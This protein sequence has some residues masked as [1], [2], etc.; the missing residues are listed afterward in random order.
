MTQ[1]YSVGRDWAECQRTGSCAC[2]E[3]GRHPT[4]G[5]LERSAPPHLHGG[6]TRSLRRRQPISLVL[7][8]IL[9][10]D[11]HGDS[12]LKINSN[13]KESKHIIKLQSR[14]ERKLEK[15]ALQKSEFNSFQSCPGYFS[16]LLTSLC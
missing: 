2:P 5:F 10:Q 7:P 14:R 12:V 3:P 6:Y 15:I 8:V 9:Q 4:P 13:W 11:I 1:F 16:E